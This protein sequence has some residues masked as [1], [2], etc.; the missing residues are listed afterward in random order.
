MPDAESGLPRSTSLVDGR[1]PDTFSELPY[2]I[3]IVWVLPLESSVIRFAGLTKR[4]GSIAARALGSERVLFGGDGDEGV[5]VTMDSIEGQGTHGRALGVPDFQTALGFVALVAVLFFYGGAQLQVRFGEIG[6][7]AAEWLFLFLPALLVVR[8]TRSNPIRTLCLRPPSLPGLAGAIVLI[9]GAIPLVWTIGWLQTF[10]LPVPWELLQGLE[11][12]VTAETTTRLLWLLLLLALTPAVC[13]EFVFRG[14]LLG[15]SRSLAPWRMVVLN[16]LVFGAF[17]LSFETVIR[18]LPTASLGM[19]IAWAV[20][21]TGSIWVGMLMHFVNNATIVVLVSTPSLQGLFSDPTAPP[22]L[23]LV[24]IGVVAFSIGARTLA[25]L[26]IV[27][28]EEP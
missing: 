27:S 6:L 22:P 23:W 10:V 25:G 12:L 16:G 13:E 5:T 18:F 11:E 28:N 8:V 14:V 21:R 2:T 19:V 26:P 24:S 17:H 7:L 15:G 1:S 3:T 20:W 4:Y 9:A